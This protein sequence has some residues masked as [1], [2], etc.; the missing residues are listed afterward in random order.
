MRSTTI[1]SLVLF[2][3]CDLLDDKPAGD[4]GGAVTTTGA[5]TT[6]T[7]T[8]GTGTGTTG[9]TSTTSTSPW[10]GSTHPCIGNRTDAM[11][12]DDDQTVYVGCGSTTAGF[13][14]YRSDDAGMTW[15][16]VADAALQDFRVSS[17]Q[18]SGGVLY[19]AGIDTTSSMRVATVDGDTVTSVWDAGNQI[20]NSFHVGTFRRNDAGVAIAESLTGTGLVWRD[21]DSAPFIDGS[22]WPT[23]GGSYQILDLVEF[24]GEFFGVGSTIATPPHVFIHNSVSPLALTPVQLASWNGELW[25]IDVDAGG[26]I[27]GGINQVDNEGMIFWSGADP[28]DPAQ[29]SSI[30]LADFVSTSPTWIR[31]VCRSG[32]LFAAVGE[33][34]TSEDPI[35]V[36]STDGGATWQDWTADI[37]AGA[38]ALHKCKMW[39]DGRLAITGQSGYFALYTP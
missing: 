30:S 7:A 27:A 9:T 8:G 24:Q 5:T 17:I 3:G 26:I 37:P 34:P 6:G 20:W 19:I 4:T 25:G 16:S 23:D 21:S 38:Q 11:W 12:W 39:P 18:R 1:L 22:S 29:W 15:V 31:G 13:G 35:L 28:L 2:A 10:V 36:V 14:L 33:F 32:S